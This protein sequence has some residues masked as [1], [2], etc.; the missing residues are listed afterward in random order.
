MAV[1]WWQIQDTVH[2]EVVRVRAQARSI[3]WTDQSI[4]GH[5][6]ATIKE[7]QSRRHPRRF[8]LVLLSKVR[9]AC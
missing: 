9:L 4:Y 2:Q 7:S 6:P 8:S 1:R 5:K 3:F